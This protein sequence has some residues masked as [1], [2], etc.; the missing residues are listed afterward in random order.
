[1]KLLKVVQML[2]ACAVHVYSKRIC[3]WILRDNSWGLKKFVDNLSITKHFKLH[4]P[5]NEQWRS[6]T[7]AHK[8][9][10]PGNFALR[11]MLI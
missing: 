1:M 5:Y 7:R 8:G 6:Y 11:R 3:Q 4:G 10:C 2:D 9:L